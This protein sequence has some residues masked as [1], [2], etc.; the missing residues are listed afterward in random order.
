VKSLRSGG[1][2]FTLVDG[3]YRDRGY[4]AATID[5]PTLGGTVSL[6]RGGFALARITRTPIVP[7]VAR[8][9]GRRVEITCGDPIPPTQDE[10]AM[11]AAV[12]QWL[13]EYLLEFPG[14]ISARTLQT[15]RPLPPGR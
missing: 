14:E 7:L 11:A 13:G 5:A 2:V 8:K 9:C 1:Y 4:D 12:A 10:E 3:G 15:L 6:A